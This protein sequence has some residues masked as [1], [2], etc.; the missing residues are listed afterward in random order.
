[1]MNVD[2]IDDVVIPTPPDVYVIQPLYM[3]P[4]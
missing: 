2:D 4:E 1:M 3:E